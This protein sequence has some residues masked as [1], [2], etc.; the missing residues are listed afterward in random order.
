[1]IRVNLLPWRAE[2]RNAQRK[3]LALLA[4]VV[5]AIGAGIIIAIHG[6]IAGYIASQDGRNTYL[7]GE[8]ARLDKEIEEI[9][10]LRDEI[11]ALLA[12]KQVIERLQADRSQVVNL[13]DQLVR[14][15][16]DGVYL[17][18]LKQQGLGV[19]LVGY[20]QSNARVSTLM[21]NFGN[22]PHLENPELVEIKA[23]AVNNKRVSEFT[24]NVSLKRTETEDASKAGKGAPAKSDASK[25]G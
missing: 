15:T 8:N 11:A 25:K 17:K 1:M 3:H 12:R 2:R 18:S 6:V 4:G 7:K 14:Q 24:M 23:A 10:K 9:K 21:R 5:A 20:A 16:P 13:L 19:N 22:S